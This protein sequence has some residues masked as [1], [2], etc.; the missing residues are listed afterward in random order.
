MKL[1]IMNAL[2]SVPFSSIFLKVCVE[3]ILYLP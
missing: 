1:K 2:V 3:L